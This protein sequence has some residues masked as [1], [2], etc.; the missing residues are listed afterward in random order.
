MYLIESI[1]EAVSHYRSAIALNPKKAES[2][3][4][5]GNALCVKNDYHNA[6]NSY[7]QALDLDPKNAPALYNLGNAY[8]MLNQF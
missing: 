5:L 7:L 2:Y 1:E 3:Y 6:I 8:Y 4:N